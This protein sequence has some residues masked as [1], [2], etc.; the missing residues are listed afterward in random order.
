MDP[1]LRLLTLVLA[2]QVGTADFLRADEPAKHWAFQP[3]RRPDVPR[4][5][6]RAWVRTPIDAFI[7]AKLEAAGLK[8]SPPADQ[9]SLL[10][11]IYLD[12]IGLPPTP[13]EQHAFLADTRPDAFAR[14]VDDLLARPEYGERW[15]RHWLDVV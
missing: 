1:R 6:D 4:V 3:V 8:P 9:R 15:A 2:V 10:R 14:V 7:L 11:R 5:R 13:E 12:L